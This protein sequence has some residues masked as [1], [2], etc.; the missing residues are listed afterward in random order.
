[1]KRNFRSGYIS[2]LSVVTLASIMLLMLTASFRHNIQN[3]EAQKKT[4]IRVDY[5]NREQA[6]LRAVLTEVPNSAIRNMMANSN[7]SGS[8]V[9]SRWERIFERALEKAKGEQALPPEQASVLGISGQSISGNTGDGGNGNIK[10]TVDRIKSQSSLNQFYVNAGTNNT[11]TLLG[12]KYP[13]SLR[14]SDGAIEKMD[15]DR[16]IITMAKTYPG[17]GQ[18]KAVPYPDVHFG[19]VAQSDNFVAKRN[20]WAFSLSSGEASKSSTGV[21]TVRKNFILSVYEVPSQLALGSAGSTILGK[22]GDG[23]DWGDI[24]ISG[25]VF[26]SRALTQGNV[27][28]DRLAARRGISL[29]DE[30][31]V[32]GVALDALTGDL[33]SREQYES[34][35]AAFYPISSSSDSGLV[36]FLPIA[37]GRDAFDDLENVTDKNSGSPTGWNLYSRPAM[38][39]VMK[40][41]VEDVLSPED[42]TPIAIS[43]TYLAGGIERKIVYTRGNNW[44]TS[45]SPKG[46]LFPFHLESDGIQRQALSVYVG[47]LPDFLRSIGADPTSVNNSLMVNANYR[48]NIRIL[49]PNIPSLPTDIALILRDTKDFTSF[50]TGFSLVTPLRT[51]LVNDVNIVPRGID[52][53]GQEVFPPISLFIPEKRFGIR[54]QPMN[55]TLKGQVNHVG[56]DSDQNA[57]PLDL[58]SG[59]NDEVLAGKIKAELYS[60]TEPEQLPPISQMNWLIVIEQVD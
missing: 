18:F 14:V 15:R 38:Q 57:R 4:Q 2:I 1:M 56:K 42:Q 13:E 54:D 36:A 55:I 3:Q 53:Q 16:P 27:R 11:S 35:N 20:W 23:S 41:R 19:Y 60:I 30:S 50:S 5:T 21:A 47:R 49:K 28:L 46:R 37:R 9:R 31:S 17:G 29:A 6:F 25:G 34:E 52:T 8:E 26:A 45:G 40:L 58:R 33:L 59:A 32:G 48:D 43:F 44:P 39:T 12:A 10:N 24:R 7:S 51:Y 22:H